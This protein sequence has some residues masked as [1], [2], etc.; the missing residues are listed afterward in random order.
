MSINRPK[1]EDYNDQ[2]KSE[3]KKEGPTRRQFVMGLAALT[4]LALASRVEFSESL[5]EFSDSKIEAKEKLNQDRLNRI[6]VSPELKEM[7]E[8]RIKSINKIIPFSENEINLNPE[9]LTEDLKNYYKKIYK[10][11]PNLKTSL[12]RAY[13]EMGAW[14]GEIEKI[15]EEEGVPTEFAY[16]AIPESHW[17]L[18]DSSS[19]GALGPYQFM[20]ETAKEY[21]LKTGLYKNEDPNIDERIDPLKAA[22]ACA[23][24][25]KDLYNTSGDWNLALSA[26]NGGFFYRYR[27]YAIKNNENV[28]YPGFIKWMG[29]KIEKE[30]KEIIEMDYFEYTVEKGD[31]LYEIADFFG[32]DYKSI[33]KE[34]EITDRDYIRAGRKIR[35]PMDSIE[36]K[37]KFFKHLMSD[38]SQNLAYPAKFFAIKELIAEHFVTRQ[39]P[40]LELVETHRTLMATKDHVA[41]RLDTLWR[42]SNHYGV[43]Q[44][45][46]QRINKMGDSTII[47]GG[48]VYQIP[49]APETLRQIATKYEMDLKFLQFCNPAVDDPDEPLPLGYEIRI[50]ELA[51]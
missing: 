47:K 26:Y 5:G 18:K 1:F 25:L 31:R 37:R 17:I 21:K 48:N 36:A 45:M 12:E 19:A 30:R 40:S 42:I 20:P 27:S 39:K 3:E 35:I 15:F 32:V 16:L 6:K 46:I 34:N 23:K 50:C 11:K 10:E 13:F 9:E 51:N 7:E 4:G 43:S 8:E 33:C 14:I 29:D 22:R 49:V 28:D 38:I 44:K 24:F 41:K 2:K